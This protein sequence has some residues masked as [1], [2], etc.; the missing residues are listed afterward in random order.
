[1]RQRNEPKVRKDQLLQ[2]ALREA[3]RCGYQNIRREGVAKAAG[4][5]VSLVTHYFETM[6]QLKRA[7]MR[8][9]VAQEDLPVLAQGLA[10]KDKHALKAP[11]ELQQLAAAAMTAGA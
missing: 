1:M 8:A 10:A 5:S 3:G 6:T 4:V 9:A 2:A 7:V 11:K